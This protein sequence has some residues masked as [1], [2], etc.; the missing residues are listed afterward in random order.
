MKFSYY[1]KENL[2]VANLKTRKIFKLLD[3]KKLDESHF[4]VKAI[5]PTR[6][7]EMFI[8][9]SKDI[10]HFRFYRKQRIGQRIV[11]FEE[12]YALL[13][14]M[15]VAGVYGDSPNTSQFSSDWYAPNDA[16]NVWGSMP[17]KVQRRDLKKMESF[18]KYK[19]KKS[20]KKKSAS[21]K[22]KTQ[23]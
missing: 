20:T 21:K 13:N 11:E 19:K 6:K 23:L 7:I 8:I 9:E 3:V 5:S 22:R 17:A 2:L 1:F 16:R 4:G 14:E 12:I 18:T 10:K 15:T